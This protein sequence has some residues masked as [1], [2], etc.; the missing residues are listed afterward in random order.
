M[1]KSGTGRKSH[2]SYFRD[3]YKRVCD[4]EGVQDLSGNTLRTSHSLCGDTRNRLYFTPCWEEGSHVIKAYC[5]NCQKGTVWTTAYQGTFC[6]PSKTS[7][8]AS[9][10]DDRV[11]EDDLLD[12]AEGSIPM[13]RPSSA[14]PGAAWRY[15]SQYH[16]EP[17]VVNALWNPTLGRIVMPAH[18]HEF[19]RD[20]HGNVEKTCVS[21]FV[22]RAL[23]GDLNRAK[24]IEIKGRGP[25]QTAFAKSGRP[26]QE[27]VFT[28][29]MISAARVCIDAFATVGVP[30]FG[31]NIQPEY[32]L[33]RLQEFP[34]ARPVV[35]LDNDQPSVEP[36]ERLTA[37]LRAFG[38]PPKVVHHMH[39]PKKHTPAALRHALESV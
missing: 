27:L 2:T 11:S 36:R 16:I 8:V 7:R 20:G 19:A 28:E 9:G 29:D 5:H 18:D 13:D 37:L 4:A 6:P 25:L 12:A 23:P 3:D 39:D 14:A 15:F 22:A 10:G 24:Y 26:A 21:G 33:R 34:Q 38:R 32:I 31:L 17:R 30:L 35:W 1:A